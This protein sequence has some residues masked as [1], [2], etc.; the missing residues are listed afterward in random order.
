MKTYT[1]LLFDLDHTLWDYHR[2]ANET[3]HELYDQYRLK[4]LGVHSADTFCRTF[5]QVNFR[6]WDLYNRG[7]YD[8]ERLRRERFFLIFDELQLTY[9]KELPPTIAQDYLTTCPAKGHVIAGTFATL[10]TLKE[11]YTLHIITNGFSDVQLV[12]LK[13]ANLSKYFQTVTT[14]DEAGYRK[15]HEG[16]FHYALDRI[17]ATPEEC[18]MIGDNLKSDILGAQNA[19]IDS[20]YFNPSQ[21]KHNTTVTHEIQ[22]LTELLTIL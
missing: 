9:P 21:E 17:P 18:I 13:H 1:H 6:L 5:H 16:M 10:D 12:K 3:L 14:S 20:V 22:S 4:Q 15:P 19:K 2:C 7:E 8:S 11:K